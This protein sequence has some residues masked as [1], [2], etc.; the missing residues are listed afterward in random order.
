M[1]IFVTYSEGKR[2]V[3][4]FAG[5]RGREEERRGQE[6]GESWTAFS[7]EIWTAFSGSEV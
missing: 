1:I 3:R 6:L 4:S 2:F 5:S 7:G